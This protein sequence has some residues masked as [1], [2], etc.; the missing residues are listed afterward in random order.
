MTL[1]ST[2]ALL[3]GASNGDK[4]VARPGN[5]SGGAHEGGVVVHDEQRGVTRLIHA[6]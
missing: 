3:N 5:L 1:Q 4:V 6:A 2:L